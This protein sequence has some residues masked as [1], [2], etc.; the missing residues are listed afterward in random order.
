MPNIINKRKKVFVAMSGGVDSSVSTALLVAQGYNVCGVFIKGWY[1]EGIPCTWR[2]DRRDAM[3][4]AAILSI[5][6][7]TFDFSREYKKHIVDYMIAEYKEGRTPNPDIMCNKYIKFGSFLKKALEMGADLIATG[8]YAR[9]K[10]EIKSSKVQPNYKLKVGKDN[11]KDQ[12]YFLWTLTQ[13]QLKRTIFPIGEYEKPEVREMARKFE[14]PVS[15]KKDSQ[16]LC[17]VGEFKMDEFLTEYI[18]PK[19]GKILDNNGVQV[20]KHKGVQFYTIGQ[21]HKTGAMGGVPLYVVSKD[22]NKNILV[23]APDNER[24][25][26]DTKEV[27]ISNVNWTSGKMPD[28]SKTYSARFRYRQPLQECSLF[29]VSS[30]KFQVQ[31]KMPQHAIA[32]GQSLVIY[33]NDELLGGGIII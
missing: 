30:F 33:E 21:R 12:S 29:Q 28:T 26:Y 10:Q 1:P 5:P 25:K 18:K 16:G 22:I 6:F 13:D 32:P 19:E 11:N 2:E 15:E 7:Y 27:E 23:V 17:F 9:L 8:H 24:K 4:V 31:F 20:G 14:L 3:A